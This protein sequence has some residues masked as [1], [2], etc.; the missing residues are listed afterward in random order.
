MMPTES[1]IKKQCTL[2]SKETAVCHWTSLPKV[3]NTTEA[4][5]CILFVYCI[6][7]KERIDK[8]YRS[9]PSAGS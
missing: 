1:V 5:A 9:N 6:L 4:L 2:N 3:P 8:G 7:F